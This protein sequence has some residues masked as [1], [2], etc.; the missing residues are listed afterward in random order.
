MGKLCDPAS[1][2]TLTVFSFVAFT[3]FCPMSYHLLKSLIFLKSMVPN[4]V[5][6]MVPPHMAPVFPQTYALPGVIC[7]QVA[8]WGMLVQP[9]I[10]SVSL[11]PWH[12]SQN[13]LR[14]SQST[15]GPPHHLWFSSLLLWAWK[16]FCKEQVVWCRYREV[17]SEDSTVVPSKFIRS[18]NQR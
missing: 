9:G 6:Q 17:G 15:L 13:M 3:V 10:C 2:T 7:C 11:V 1:H 18:V 16:V 14:Y 4:A 12:A 8:H 5:L